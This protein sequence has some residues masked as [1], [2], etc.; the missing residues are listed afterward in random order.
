[1][2]H[3]QIS[4]H[5]IWRGFSA[6]AFIVLVLLAIALLNTPAAA[7]NS[8]GP[9]DTVIKL[10][11]NEYDESTVAVGL[12]SSGGVIEVL[13][14][15]DGATWTIMLTMPDGTSCVVASGEAWI[16]VLRRAKGQI[17]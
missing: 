4:D 9:R 10:L 7:Q 1:M 6:I 13:T 8:C 16:D 17:S 14:A 2:W 12:A 3:R 11:G 15:N 5:P